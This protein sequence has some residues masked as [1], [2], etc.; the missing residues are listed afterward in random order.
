MTEMLGWKLLDRFMKLFRCSLVIVLA[1]TVV[2]IQYGHGGVTALGGPTTLWLNFLYSRMH[3]RGK[4]R[5]KERE[6]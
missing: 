6:R 1:D 3:A 4:Y 2:W 5:Q